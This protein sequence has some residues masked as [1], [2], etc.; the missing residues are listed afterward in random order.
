MSVRSVRLSEDIESALRYVARREKSE[1][2]A[3]LRKLTRL[4]FETYVTRAYRQAEVTLR[5][6]S[7]LLGLGLRETLDLMA[8]AGV[9]GNITATEVL[10]GLDVL[11]GED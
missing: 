2:A 11:R 8:E 7:E 4:G 10:E 3:S 1:L 9:R 6:A 5:E